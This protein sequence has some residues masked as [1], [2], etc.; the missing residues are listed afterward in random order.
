MVRIVG[1]DKP[2]SKKLRTF[3]DEKVPITLR[4]CHI[5]QNKF[6]NKYEV[7]PNTKINQFSVEFEIAD[8]KIVGSPLTPLSDLNQKEEFDKITVG[9][10]VIKC[11][12]PQRVGTKQL[13]MQLVKL[14]S[15]YGK[16]M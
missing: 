13:L 3:C 10:K 6:N 11:N 5:E 2:H 1:F 14:P 8:L 16:R 4:H 15:H 9:A 12:D 7:V